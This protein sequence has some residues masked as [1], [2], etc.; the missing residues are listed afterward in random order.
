MSSQFQSFPHK[1]RHPKPGLGFAVVRL[2]GWSFKIIG[3]LLIGAAVAGFILMLVKAGPEL[4]SAFD[5][6]PESTFAGFV[7]LVLLG[8]LLIFP[9]L[10]LAGAVLA[11]I[12]FLFGRWGTNRAP[13]MTGIEPTSDRAISAQEQDAG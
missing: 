6:S 11:G 4:I 12:G 7:F 3:G 1:S 10:G 13:I 2:I 5:Q 8:Y 9:L